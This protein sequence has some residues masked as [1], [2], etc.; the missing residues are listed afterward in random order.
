MKYDEKMPPSLFVE[1]FGDYP[2]IRVLDFFLEY[3]TFDYSKKDICRNADVSWNTL[4]SFWNQLEE[5]SIIIH[6]RKVG[7]AEMYK[8]NSQ[9]VLVKQLLELDRKLLKASFDKIAPPQKT[10]SMAADSD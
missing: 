2:F 5:M 9:N 3:D 10:I 8:I 4:E 7:K 6:T 1:F